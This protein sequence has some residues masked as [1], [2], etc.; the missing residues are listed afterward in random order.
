MNDVE[1][2]KQRTE[3]NAKLKGKYKYKEV[4]KATIE[5]KENGWRILEFQFK[6]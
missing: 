6:I 2:K 5:K 4:F 1:Y 3:L